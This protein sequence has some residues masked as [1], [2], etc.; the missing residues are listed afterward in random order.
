MRLYQQDGKSWNPLQCLRD[1]EVRRLSGE[2]LDTHFLEGRTRE[3]SKA[4]SVSSFAATDSSLGEGRTSRGRKRHS[5][6]VQP[7]QRGHTRQQSSR[8]Q[9]AERYRMLPK[10][11]ENWSLTSEEVLSNYAWQQSNPNRMINRH[12]QLINPPT[13]DERRSDGVASKSSSFEYTRARYSSETVPLSPQVSH[14]SPLG[15]T[16]SA[17]ATHLRN[18]PSFA[19][20]STSVNRSRSPSPV[21]GNSKH[22]RQTSDL[23]DI[24]QRVRKKI[25][26]RIKGDRSGVSSRAHSPTRS[27]TVPLSHSIQEDLDTS[28]TPRA[29]TMPNNLRLDIDVLARRPTISR[30]PKPAISTQE[31]ESKRELARTRA[32]LIST[33]VTTR[34]MLPS[35]ESTSIL[36]IMSCQNLMNKFHDLDRSLTASFEHDFPQAT[37]DLLSVLSTVESRQTQISNKVSSSLTKT[38]T[39]TAVKIAEIASEQT[40]TLLLQLKA[41]EDKMDALEYRTNSGWTHEKTLHLVFLLLEYI[42]MV[43][44]WHLWV[45][46]SVLQY[47]KRA[48]YGVWGI[49][50]GI[51]MGSIRLVRWMFFL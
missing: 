45:L 50:W 8:H 43:V 10:G 27:E 28:K 40:S 15:R 48:I 25:Q 7:P 33:G 44:L 2:P 26:N 11:L 1:R 23:L 41:V 6:P 42:V 36:P 34:A 13:D 30:R 12:Y 31:T 18:V 3:S 37:S 16:T 20:S 17:K 49:L 9:H 24:P 32:R 29:V 14:G 22:T 38:R 21:R 35:Q 19:M 5:S 51:V 47:G 39:E 4:G 46:I